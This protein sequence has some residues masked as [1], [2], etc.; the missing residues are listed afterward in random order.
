METKKGRAAWRLV[1]LA[2]G[3]LVGCEPEGRAVD[4]EHPITRGER[5]AIAERG[6]DVTRALVATLS[7][8][9]STAL[10]EEGP[11]GAVRACSNLAQ[12]LTDSIAHAE[13]VE[14]GRTSLRWRNPANA[15]DPWDE[16]ALT[17]FGRLRAEGE[18]THEGMVMVMS[19]GVARYYRPLVLVEGC[20]RC[21]GPAETLDPDVLSA[22]REAYP[23]DRATGY[24]AGDLRG[25]VRVTIPR[26]PPL[27]GH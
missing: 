23:D 6:E 25:L 1:V 16:R 15:P 13:G 2:A 18:A 24:A 7:S 20:L 19:P 17:Y 14:I 10:R 4:V 5:Q 9:L 11:W 3:I 21:H 27:P 8:R 22:I 12:A 26:E